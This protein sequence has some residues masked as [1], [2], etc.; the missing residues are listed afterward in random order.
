MPTETRPAGGFQFLVLNGE[1]SGPIDL[2]A[3]GNVSI[4]RG[5]GCDVRVRDPSVSRHHAVIHV[6]T[7]VIIQDLGSADGTTIRDRADSGVMSE[8]MSVRQL[9]RKEAELSV[10]DAA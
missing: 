10:G 1:Q 9:V 3:S 4:G 5:E 8:T 7:K 6:G 2:P